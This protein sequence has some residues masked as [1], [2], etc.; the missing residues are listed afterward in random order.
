MVRLLLAVCVSA[1]VLCAVG[2]AHAAV[3]S[4]VPN[5]ADLY[6]LDHYQYYT[7]G[8]QWTLPA[9]EVL[10]DAVLYFQNINNWTYEPN[11][12]WL[13]IHLLDNPPLGVKTF[14]DNQGGG[15]AFAGQGVLVAVYTDNDPVPVPLLSYSLA[16]LGLLGA[17]ET[18]AANGVVG[19]GI[20]PDC[21]YYND[22]IKFK[23]TTTIIP[24]PSGLA[25]LG[26]GLLPLLRRIR[27]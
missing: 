9:N 10:V 8:F 6:D 5:P 23:I 4:F 18:Y 17:L 20:D 14:T 3:Y 12:N 19:F 22:G 21:H 13:Y 25:V 15:D 27:R 1:M 16:S 24:E 7:W 11:K 2:A 26:L